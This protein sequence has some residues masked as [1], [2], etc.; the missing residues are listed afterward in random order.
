MK[1][2]TFEK[3]KKT[4]PE[5][6]LF[7]MTHRGLMVQILYQVI[8]GGGH[9]LTYAQTGHDLFIGPSYSTLFML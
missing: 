9:R 2:R 7:W 1:C 3:E 6:S 8:H 5:I 4:L